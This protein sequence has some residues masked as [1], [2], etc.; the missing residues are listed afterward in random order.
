[1]NGVRG[2][3]EADDAIRRTALESFPRGAVIFLD[4]EYM[5]GT[6]AKMREYYRAWTRQVLADGRYRPGF[7]AH[8]R[9][10]DLIYQ[11]VKQEYLRAGITDDPPF[12]IASKSEAF[13]TDNYPQ[14]VG[15]SFA[16]TWQG[17]L[18]IVEEWNGQALAIDVNVSQVPDPSH[19]F[20]TQ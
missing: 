15:H 12:W 11:D 4:I 16:T 9:N 5:K 8:T 14:D 13:T 19:V 6:P 7:Y 1:V 3:I 2:K 18:D 20:T 10:A 17:M